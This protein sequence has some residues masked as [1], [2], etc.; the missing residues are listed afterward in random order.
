MKCCFKVSV[1]IVIITA[2]SLLS[3]AAQAPKAAVPKAATG[4]VHATH[5]AAA[6]P[7]KPLTADQRFKNI[8]VLKGL[9]LDDFMATMGV[10]A[11]SLG[12]DCSECHM[13]AGTVT[14][15]W[16]ADNPNKI[17]A[18]QMVT[19][20][21]TINKTNFGGRQM[22][23]CWSCHRGRDRPLLTPT[24]D[25]IYGPVTQYMDDVLTPAEGQ[26]SPDDILGKYYQ[27]IG[28]KEKVSGLKSFAAKGK[29]VGFGGFG[30]GGSVE[31]SAKF[32]DERATIMSFP[33]SPDRGH[34]IRTFNGHEAWLETPLTV[35]G[36]YQLTGGELDGA[37]LDA[38]LSFP[39]QIKEVLSDLRV[40]LPTT[41]H[42]ELGPAAQSKESGTTASSQERLVNVVQG[43]GPRGS[44]ATLYFDAKSGLLVRIVRSSK[45][46]IGRVPTQIDYS[47]YRDVNGVKLPFHLL[48]SWLDGRDEIQLTDVQTNVPVD[49]S[50]FGRPA[51]MPPMPKGK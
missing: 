32:P 23:T 35:L 26:P 12:Y 19:M 24:L 20:M 38:Q 46:A 37:K 41:I 15:D 11:A 42:D 4:S 18:R 43:T 33:A 51:P 17:M 50:K 10:M 29:S 49:E 40:S 1:V 48:F 27:A 36:S 34:S 7:G 47:D 13:G 16:A 8:Q 44:L 39:G 28:G 25:N 2:G 45:G 6:E 5:Q 21:R 14:V 9:P 3:V 22:V 31:I 30:G